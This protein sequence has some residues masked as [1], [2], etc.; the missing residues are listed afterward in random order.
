MSG[1]VIPVVSLRLC[2]E[3][4]SRVDDREQDVG[5]KRAEDRQ[6]AQQEDDEARELC[7]LDENG[8][9]QDWPQGREAQHYGDDHTAA[10]Q[11]GQQ[12]AHCA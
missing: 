2:A 10:H 1:I 11:G 6:D 5:Y 7:V 9:E 4:D 8:V 3:L 12:V